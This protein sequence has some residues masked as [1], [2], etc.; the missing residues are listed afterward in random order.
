VARPDGAVVS[1]M[2]VPPD[3]ASSL[4]TRFRR[5]LPPAMKARDQAAVTVIRSALAAIDNARSGGAA[6]TALG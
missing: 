2:S 3:A 5:A 1:A 4:H 6:G